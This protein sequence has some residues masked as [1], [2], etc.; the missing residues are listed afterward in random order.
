MV[1]GPRDPTPRSPDDSEPLSAED[2][3]F[4]KDFYS[5]DYPMEE[6]APSSHPTPEPMSPPRPSLARNPLFWLAWL[7][8]FLFFPTSYSKD[9]P[10]SW[11]LSN[12]G[13]ILA[14]LLVALSNGQ[15]APLLTSTTSYTSRG[16][17]K[18]PEVM[19][20]YWRYWLTWMAGAI[21]LTT[22]LR[23]WYRPPQQ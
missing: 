20:P 18:T 22:Y 10:L 21:M 3:A 23:V 5:K 9:L 13:T 1:P 8:P 7:V 19:H 16:I 6:P 14:P 4:L 12:S 17:T 2:L 11:G 15:T